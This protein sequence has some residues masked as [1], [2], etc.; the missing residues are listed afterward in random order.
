MS[1]PGLKP[2]FSHPE[3]DNRLYSLKNVSFDIK[4]LVKI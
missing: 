2:H 1:N 4:V 3:S